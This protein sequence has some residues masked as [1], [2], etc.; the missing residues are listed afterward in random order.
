MQAW[1]SENTVFN[2]R[3]HVFHFL[4]AS[5]KSTLIAVLLQQQQRVFLSTVPRFF[6][7][8]H[9]SRPAHCHLASPAAAIAIPT[10]LHGH[11]L[12]ASRGYPRILCRTLPPPMCFTILLLPLKRWSLLCH[13]A[14]AVSCRRRGAVQQHLQYR[15]A[16]LLAQSRC[17]ALALPSCSIKNCTDSCC[18]PPWTTWHE[19]GSTRKPA[20]AHGCLLNSS[21]LKK[22]KARIRVY[23]VEKLYICRLLLPQ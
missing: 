4:F 10:R 17:A 15:T 9:K 23:S 12:Q 6:R 19:C 1:R 22:T 20:A 18:C 11:S 7:P 5:F 21:S 13:S 2:R 8:Y 14:A 16:A 3:F